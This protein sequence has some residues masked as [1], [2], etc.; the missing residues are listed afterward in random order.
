[1]F[2]KFVALS[3]L[4]F[5]M[6]AAYAAAPTSYK[7]YC[8]AAQ[9][10]NPPQADSSINHGDEQELF[11]QGDFVYSISYTDDVDGKNA[12]RLKVLNKGTGKQ[13]LAQVFVKNEMPSR[14]DLVTETADTNFTCFEY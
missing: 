4:S 2:A 10:G 14:I 6:T 3:V 5:S 13:N 9:P 1:M 12:V 7:G 8:M 11:T